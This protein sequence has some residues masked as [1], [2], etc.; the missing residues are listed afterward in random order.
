MQDGAAVGGLPM[1]EAQGIANQ[2][3]GQLLGVLLDPIIAGTA[4]LELPDNVKLRDLLLPENIRV[5]VKVSIVRV[6]AFF[7]VSFLINACFIKVCI[8][9]AYAWLKEK[10]WRFLLLGFSCKKGQFNHLMLSVLCV[11]M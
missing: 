4:A 2:S 8:L 11:Q 10:C 7:F 6:S 9:A 5:G 1:L 3:E